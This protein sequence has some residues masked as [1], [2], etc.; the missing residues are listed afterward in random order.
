MSR[1]GTKFFAS[2]ALAFS[3]VVA[4][5]ASA[6]TVTY[7]FTGSSSGLGTGNLGVSSA[8]VISG[9]LALT[10]EALDEFGAAGII[11]RNDLTGLGVVG[12]PG[13]GQETNQVGA[14]SNGGEA[15]IFDFAPNSVTIVETVVFELGMEAGSLDVLADNVL[16]ETISWTAATGTGSTGNSSIAHTFAAP[17]SAR[18]AQSFTFRAVEDSF[19][20]SSL[21]V[22]P[23]PEP[24]SLAI[25]SIAISCVALSRRRS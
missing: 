5:Q 9:G 3:L 2:L 12:G 17:L 10:I 19:R 6:S 1:L 11:A 14:D 8:N 25:A 20:V 4:G 7:D 23:I 15:L 18:T 16:L 22:T 24:A 21:T 13:T